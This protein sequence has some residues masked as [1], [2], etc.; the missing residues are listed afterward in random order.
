[1]HSRLIAER[2]RLRAPCVGDM[3]VL[4]RMRRDV[5]LQNLLLAYP[6]P[7]ATIDLDHWLERRKNEP[8]GAF[9]VVADI[10]SDECLGYVQLANVHGRGRHGALGIALS[11]V[12]QGR[13]IGREA[14]TLFL[15]YARDFMNLRKVELE[16]MSSNKRAVRLYKSLGF[17]EVGV[18]RQHYFDGTDW[19]DVLLMELLLEGS[20]I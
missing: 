8:R 5:A 1:M 10:E 4:G 9:F 13:G 18:R 11:D 15:Q 6:D 7:A 2:I 19:R 3:K 17:V 16:V 12:A 14:L 20:N